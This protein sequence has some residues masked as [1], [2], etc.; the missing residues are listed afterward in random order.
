MHADEEQQKQK[1]ATHVPHTC[2]A[3]RRRPRH[4]WDAHLHPTHT[5][6]YTPVHS[7]FSFLYYFFLSSS[8][9]SI[10]FLFCPFVFFPSIFLIFR[11]FLFPSSFLLSSLSF[12]LS[13]FLL[14]L[15][16]LSSFLLFAPV[17]SLLLPSSPL[18]PS[19]SSS[20]FTLTQLFLV[21]IDRDRGRAARHPSCKAS[22]RLTAFAG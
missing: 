14:H 8:S 12:S 15:S 18:S 13:F 3:A 19:S 16:R 11:L 17:S 6:L 4:T 1:Q 2:P 21:T 7:H 22:H 5:H 10:S 9:L 20:S